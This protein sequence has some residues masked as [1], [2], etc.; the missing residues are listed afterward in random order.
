MLLAQILH[1]LTQNFG[2][3]CFFLAV[4]ATEWWNK[5][6]N[7]PSV[8]DI[9]SVLKMTTAQ[10]ELPTNAVHK[11]LLLWYFDRFL[12]VAAG[13]DYYGEDIRHY[14]RITS[15]MKVNGAQ[16]VCVTVASEAFGLLVLENCRGKWQNIFYYKETHGQGS[17]IPTTGDE[18]AAF[19]ARWTDSKCG[20]IKFGGWAPEAYVYFEEAKEKIKQF[21]TVDGANGYDTQEYA[22]KIMREEHNITA[23]GPGKKRKRGKKS[24]AP[25]QAPPRKITREEE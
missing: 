20:R 4:Y 3:C 9:F 22:L 2:R 18:S 8:E 14:Q 7:I 21:R 25:K 6:K 24:N 15:K 17:A 19:K 12:P 10:L 23:D 5:H 11:A 16:K 13:K 1:K